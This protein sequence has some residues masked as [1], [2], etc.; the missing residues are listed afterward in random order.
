ML[1]WGMAKR[2]LG[3]TTLTDA[4]MFASEESGSTILLP[5]YPDRVSGRESKERTR[6]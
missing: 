4:Y 2:R 3:T 6:I 1:R 5:E